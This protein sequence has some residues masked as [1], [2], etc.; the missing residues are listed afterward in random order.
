MKTN[1]IKKEITDAWMSAE[2]TNMSTNELNSREMK[3]FWKSRPLSENQKKL[4]N[5]FLTKINF[6]EQQMNETENEWKKFLSA[7]EN[8]AYVIF[9]FNF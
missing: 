5:D 3:Y 9:L 4:M 8:N 7:D 2:E 1:E 6:F